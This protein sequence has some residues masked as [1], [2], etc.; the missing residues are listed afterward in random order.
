MLRGRYRWM[1]CAMLFVATTINYID[2]QIIGLLKPILQVQFSWSERDYAAIVFSF[3][4]AYAIGLL[5]S[6]RVMDKL[7]TK[8]GFALAI[9]LWSVAAVAHAFADWFPALVVPTINLDENTGLSVVSLTGAAAGF[10]L[11]RF[12]L[13]LGEAGNFPASIKTVA[14]WFP[15]KER[16]FATGIFNSGTNIGA[17]I[18]PLIVPALVAMWGWQEAFVATGLLG[19]LWLIWWW[20][21]YAAPEAHPQVTPD[22]L[23]LIRSDPPESTTPVPWGS[24]VRYPQAWAFALGKFLTDPVWW[25]YLFW[26]PDFFNRVYGLNVKE[27]GLPIVTIYLIT[28]VG[29]IG[30]GWLSSFFL[31]QG[32]SVNAARKVTMLICAIA[33][34]PIMAAPR[35]SNLW[36]AVLLVSLA[37]SAHQGWSANL[38]TLVSD[39]F[40]RRAVGSVVGFG[41]MCGAIGGMCLTLVVGEILQRTGSYVGVFLIA[42]F[43]YLAGLLVIHLLVPRLAPAQID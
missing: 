3:Q 8:K 19:F 20:F 27:M 39:M 23:A 14:E 9:I 18:T 24:I 5:L 13:G 2:R 32:W 15:R 17:L 11:A 10:A 12:F 41:G 29:S 38:F 33:V 4:L 40:P 43:A 6:G 42:G 31:K 25:L 21:S 34:M 22:E 36:A 16:A 37:A 26:I 7:G 30:G 1:I 35:V 28:D